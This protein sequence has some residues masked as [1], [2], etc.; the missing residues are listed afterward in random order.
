MISLRFVRAIVLPGLIFQ[1]VI[2]A[3][4]YATGRELVEFFLSNG[5]RGGAMG[6][7]V[8]A[9]VWGVVLAISFEFARRYKSYNYKHFFQQLLGRA[10]FFYEVAYLAALLLILSVIGSAAGA[11][12]EETFNV[13]SIVGTV[14]LIVSIGVLTFYGSSLIEKVLASWSIVLYLVY[15]AF[16][17]IGF[18]KFGD[19]IAQGFE[20]KNEAGSWALGGLQYAS[21]NLAIVPTILFCIRH[22]ASPRETVCAGFLAG[23]LA[24]IP[25]VLFYCVMV[26]FYPVILEA[27]VPVNVILAAMDIPL[28]Q[29]VFQIVILGTFIETGTAL[30]H[31][32]NERLASNYEVQQKQMPIFLRP[33][34]ALLVMSLAIFVGEKIG[35][36]KLIAQGYGMLTYVFLAVFIVPLFTV[37]LYRLVV[38]RDTHRVLPDFG[39]SE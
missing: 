27:P 30:L 21:Y 14:F 26:G 15:A 20:Q 22:L 34:V 2:I 25:G 28:F 29:T 1:S 18:I 11:L 23:V 33:I 35:L 9:L 37:G 8:A 13:P 5:P 38:K 32:L 19:H 16:L 39:L 10:W 7:M 36:V 4:G 24:V 31:A 17:I 6:M 3:G 12:A